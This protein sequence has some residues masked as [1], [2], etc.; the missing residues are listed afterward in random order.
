MVGGRTDHGGCAQVARAACTAV[1]ALA[2]SLG[3][4]FD[5]LCEALLPALLLQ[6]ASA[7]PTVGRSAESAV[8]ALVRAS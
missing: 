8:S 2:E 6:C 1:E 7:T 3:P 5:P 4:H